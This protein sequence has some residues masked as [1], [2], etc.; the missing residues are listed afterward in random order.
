MLFRERIEWNREQEYVQDY[1]KSSTYGSKKSSHNQ[2]SQRF[3]L[4]WVVEDETFRSINW[5]KKFV[6]ILSSSANS[7]QSD[8]KSLSSWRSHEQNILTTVQDWRVNF[9]HKS[10][11]DWRSATISNSQTVKNWKK[12]FRHHKLKIDSMWTLVDNN[13]IQP[14]TKVVGNVS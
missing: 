5:I 10:T 12:I 8:H 7:R 3:K 14:S 11:Y 1:A 9:L 13:K 2:S 6:I 4:N